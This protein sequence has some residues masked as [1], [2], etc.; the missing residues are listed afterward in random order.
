M[1]LSTTMSMRDNL[2]RPSDGNV[3]DTA[4]VFIEGWDDTRNRFKVTLSGDTKYSNYESGIVSPGSDSNGYDVKLT[5]G[6]FSLVPTS[7]NT[8][9]KNSHEVL[10]I[11]LYLNDDNSNPIILSAN[12]Q[13]HI[14]GFGITNIYI[15]T[16]ASY[17]NNV[18]VM[19]F[20]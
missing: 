10:D 14:E 7:F 9:V 11:V 15:D 3:F 18:E 6:F 8:Q 19:L 5:G 20:G 16:P 4:Q 1:S 13:F 2:E 17:D 12:S